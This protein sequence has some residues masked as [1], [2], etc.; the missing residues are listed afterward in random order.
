MWALTGARDGR[1]A[2]LMAGVPAGTNLREA[3]SARQLREL[4]LEQ[5]LT[6]AQIAGRLGL[7]ATTIRR[8]LRELTIPAR[9]RGPRASTSSTR[10]PVVWT[11]DLAYVVGL[12]A[13]DGNLSKKPGRVAI[14]SNDTDLLDL[15]RQRLKLVTEIRPHRGGYGIRCHHL[16]WS[17]RRFYDWLISVGLTP[18]KSLTLGP[19]A[20]PDEHFTDFFRGCIDGDGSIVSYV[21]RYNTFKSPSYVYTRLYVSVASASARFIEWLQASAQRLANVAGHID[22]SQPNGRHPVWR[23]RY[24]KRESLEVLRWIYYT[25]DV[26]CLARKRRI[27]SSFLAASAGLPTRRRGRPVIV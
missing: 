22:V 7:A 9:P 23:L 18:A 10:D 13:T 25:P 4:Y 27:A 20:I 1:I 8:R 11:P 5:G 17:D 2:L 14:M 12:I 24:A 21:D 19:L 26:A 6:I 3:V 16:I 15:V